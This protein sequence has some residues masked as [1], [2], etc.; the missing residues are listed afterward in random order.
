VWGTHYLNYSTVS[1][2]GTAFS[3]WLTGQLTLADS[4]AK[5]KASA[6]RFGTSPLTVSRISVMPV[7][8]RKST[9]AD[10]RSSVAGVPPFAKPLESAIEKH[11]AC[12]APR[13]SS[14]L[15]SPFGSWLRAGQETSNVPAPEDTRATDPFP[16]IKVPFH[17]AEAF[18]VVVIGV[19][20]I[21]GLDVN[22]PREDFNHMVT[23]CVRIVVAKRCP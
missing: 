4:A 5:R 12:A 17:I 15:V 7:P 3:A 22:C 14:G 8:G 1:L 19:L 21:K 2:M 20:F 23:L 10:V 16:S 6:S 11:A 9:S 13:S 18:L